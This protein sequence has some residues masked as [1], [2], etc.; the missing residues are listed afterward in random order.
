MDGNAILTSLIE[1]AVAEKHQELVDTVKEQR[2]Y[3][4]ALEARLESKERPFEEEAAR[5]EA[6]LIAYAKYAGAGL[7]I[8]PALEG[9]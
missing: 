5:R 7:D 8:T 6:K 3:I 1:A 4:A 9:K 2:Q